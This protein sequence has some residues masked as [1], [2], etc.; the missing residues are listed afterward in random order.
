MPKSFTDEYKDSPLYDQAF[1]STLCPAKRTE[2]P[3]KL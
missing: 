1:I 3:R 2:K